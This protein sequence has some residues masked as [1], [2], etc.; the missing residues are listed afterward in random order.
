VDDCSPDACL[1]ICDEYEKNDM[2]VKVIHHQNN[3]GLYAARN[4]GIDV[5]KG[6]W[7]CFVDS[8]DFVDSYFVEG[9]LEAAANSNCLTARCKWKHTYLDTIDVK[10]PEIEFKI[11]DWFE[12]AVFLD[13]TPGY[14]LY[15][16]CWGIYHKSLFENLR[17]PC[18]R[19]TED[20]PVSTQIL[21]LAREK[22]FAVTNQTLYYYY[23]SP[24]S[25]IRGRTRLNVLDRHQAFD[26]IF[27]FWSGK[28]EPEMLDIYFKV[29]FTALVIDYTNLCRDLVEEQERYSY[30]YAL[31]KQNAN[32]AQLL[33]LKVT[34]LPPAAQGIWETTRKSKDKYILYGFGERGHEILPW[35]IYFEVNLIE[36]WDQNAERYETAGNT[37]I[38]LVKPHSG[39]TQKNDTVIMIS[40]NDEKISAVIKRN[41]RNMGYCNF[42]SC[43][44]IF[45]A[46]KYAKYKKFLPFLLPNYEKEGT[47]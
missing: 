40:V 21:W 10:Q 28:N 32:K 41:L 25:I 14:E 44:N 1:A 3:Q 22:K 20:A 46:I 36:I 30:L 31:I 17:F 33:N 12:Y 8:D 9:L 45:G 27:N 23:Q 47:I 7:V 13:N 43:E 18:F 34:S 26:W 35:L 38:L 29:Y 37:D 11:F 42:I 19:H 2:R 15:S 4:S 39:F 16:V 6:E 24:S 5:S